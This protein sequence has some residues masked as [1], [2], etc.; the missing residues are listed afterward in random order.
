MLLPSTVR[1]FRKAAAKV[2]ALRWLGSVVHLLAALYELL[3]AG[4]S[5][6]DW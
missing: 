3:R 6:W 1:R 4:V 5:R 2:A